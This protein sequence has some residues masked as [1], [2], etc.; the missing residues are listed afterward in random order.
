MVGR[1]YHSAALHATTGPRKRQDIVNIIVVYP[2]AL[3]SYKIRPFRWCI[4]FQVSTQSGIGDDEMPQVYP[5]SS[6]AAR[7]TLAPFLSITQ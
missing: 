4:S 6:I 2:S 3:S 5:T 7:R 1:I